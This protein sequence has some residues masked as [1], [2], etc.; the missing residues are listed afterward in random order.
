[1]PQRHGHRPNRY[2]K[3]IGIIGLM[4]CYTRGFLAPIRYISEFSKEI[5]LFNFHQGVSKLK[6]CK[7]GCKKKK[8]ETFWVRGY[9]LYTS[10]RENTHENR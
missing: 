5:Y 2:S 9:I 1:M 4:S 3:C 6:R 7:F 8:A 10:A